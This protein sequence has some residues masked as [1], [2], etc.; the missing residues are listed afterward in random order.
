[1]TDMPATPRV[2]VVVVTFSPGAALTAFLDSLTRAIS[3]PYDVVL[4]DNGS[5]DGS[6]EAAEQRP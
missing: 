2:R 3:A 4:S 6:V 1:M 5:T